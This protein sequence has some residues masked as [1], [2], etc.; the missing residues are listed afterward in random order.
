[1]AAVD[2]ET[3]ARYYD[4]LVKS[5]DDVPFY[6]SLAK[7]TQGRTIEL[8]AGTGRIS[9]P[10]ASAGVDM[11]CVDDSAAMLDV[12]RGKLAGRGLSVEVFR[13]DVTRLN[14]ASRFSFAFIAL[15]SFEELTDDEEREKLM[16]GVF[17]HLQPGG[18]FVCTLH[19]PEVRLRDVGVE[20]ELRL[21][22]PGNGR[23]V[24]FSLSTEFDKE[25]SLV[26]GQERIEDVETGQVIA[27]LPLSFRLTG[28][29][30]FQSLA[31]RFG[32][33]VVDLYGG[34][35]ASRYEAGKSA[36][37]IWVLTCDDS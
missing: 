8:M 22:N 7:R 23:R 35:D 37:M 24:R 15:N 18:T 31:G 11:T 29:E 28:E 36:S 21:E 12:L 19:D 2:Y 16:Q 26:H 3:L 4:A 34:Y 25:R 33:T 30:E 10:L 6:L 9:L 14:L 5:D 13:Q 1:M 27:D 20:K 17:N 32:F